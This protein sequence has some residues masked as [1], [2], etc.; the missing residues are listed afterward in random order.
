MKVKF[1]SP[2]QHD[3]TSHAVGDTAD[4][5]GA[6]A[7]SLIDCGAVEEVDPAADRAAL[8]AASKAKAEQEAADKAAA[9]QAASDKAAADQ[10]AAEQAAA[11]RAPDA[12]EG[13]GNATGLLV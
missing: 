4:L 12:A 9:E 11:A 10:A 6:A 8:R 7:K 3:R 13:Q 1:L 5:P 2:V